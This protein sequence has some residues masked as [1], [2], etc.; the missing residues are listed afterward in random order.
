M[1]RLVIESQAAPAAQGPIETQLEQGAALL[2]TACAIVALIN[3]GVLAG[4]AAAWY[5]RWRA[6]PAT[7]MRVTCAAAFLVPFYVLMPFVLW[8]WPWRGPLATGLHLHVAAVT[9][10]LAMRSFLTESLGG[11][12]W[13]EA[14][15][16][17]AAVFRRRI[18]AQIRRDHRLDRRRYKALSGQRQGWLPERIARRGPTSPPHPPG[19]IRLCVDEETNKPFDL[20]LPA[21]LATHVFL[22]GATGTGKTTTLA[23][24]SDGALANGYGVVIIDCKGGGLGG[25]AQRLA[26]RYSLPFYRVDPDSADTLGY[27]PC[28]GDAASVANKLIG[29]FQYGPTAEI[30][31]NIAMEMLPA[32]VRGLQAAGCPVTLDTLYRALTPGG[33]KEL[34]SS[35]GDHA[36]RARIASLADHSGDR[37]GASGQSGLRHRFGALLEGRFGPL[38][39]MQ[40]ALDLDAVLASPCVVYIAL[41]TLASSEDVELM[42]RVFAQDIKQ[43][44]FRRIRE[45]DAGRQVTPVLA[46]WDEFAALREAE[47]LVDLLLQARQAL[48]PTVVST[49]YLPESVPLRKAVLGA[50]LLIAHRVEG[51]DAEAIGNQFGTRRAGELTEQV[52][53][54]TGVSNMG[55]RRRVEKFTVNPNELRTFRIGQAALKSIA[56]RRYSIVRMYETRD[57][58]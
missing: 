30:Y 3:P 5:W 48:M 50:G 4:A 16:L 18:D 21:D 37:V 53:F 7:L 54:E 45:I 32:T 27:D 31:K 36:L 9:T 22:A 52:D 49:Q 47:Q 34:A 40:H 23:R 58:P 13:F 17:V 43:L 28:R 42:G 10:P 25:V 33:L 44:C 29:A 57:E 20:A 12:A 51:E 8:A 2:A 6:R 19:R 1:A 26:H 15:L 14:A 24:L 46:V 55:S 38:F 41:S 56:Q 35:I 11:P 39:R